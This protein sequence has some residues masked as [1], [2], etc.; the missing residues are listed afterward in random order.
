[1]V[2]LNHSVVSFNSDTLVKGAHGVIVGVFVTKTGS[3]SDKVVFKIFKWKKGK[4]G[5]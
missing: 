2:E 3:G 1:M 5:I 4:I